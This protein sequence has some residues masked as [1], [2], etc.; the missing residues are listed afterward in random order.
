MET[1]G[2]FKPRSGLAQGLPLHLAGWHRACPYIRCWLLA[3]LLAMT[4]FA[5]AGTP[6]GRCGDREQIVMVNDTADIEDEQQQYEFNLLVFNYDGKDYRWTGDVMLT[7]DG[8]EVVNLSNICRNNNSRYIIGGS[9]EDQARAWTA[10]DGCVGVARG[11]ING[12]T[13]VT[14]GLYDPHYEKVND[15]DSRA[16]MVRVRVGIERKWYHHN[17]TMGIK[18]TWRTINGNEVS[19]HLK[20]TLYAANTGNIGWPTSNVTA[21]NF[22]RKGNHEMQFE[23]TFP[24][25]TITVGYTPVSW[26]SR[27]QLLREMPSTTKPYVD[28]TDRSAHWNSEDWAA[29]DGNMKKTFRVESNFDPVVIYPRLERYLASDYSYLD[30][31]FQPKYDRDYGVVVIGGYP[32][33]KNI[34]ATPNPWDK[35][36]SL[37]WGEEVPETVA[38]NVSDGK[39]YVYRKT[40]DGDITNLTSNGVAYNEK[41]FK[42]SRV[43]NMNVD[44]TYIVSYVPKSWQANKPVDEL[45]DTLANVKVEPLGNFVSMDSLQAVKGQAKIKVNWK[46]SQPIGISGNLTFKLYH[47][48]D[49]VADKNW[50][51]VADI[52]ANNTLG[53]NYSYTHDVSSFSVCA[54]HYYKVTITAMDKDYSAQTT[55]GKSVNVDGGIVVGTLNASKGMYSNVVKLRWD[56]IQIGDPITYNVYRRLL[57]SDSKFAP[58]GM[59]TDSKTSYTYEDYTVSP[60]DYY[61]YQVE[62]LSQC[63][64]T[65]GTKHVGREFD[66]ND[67]FCSTTGVVSGTINFGSG[68]AVKDVKVM[69]N[70][71]SDDA[72]N[73]RDQYHSASFNYV[74]GSNGASN[75]VVERSSLLVPLTDAQGK[76]MFTGKPWSIQMYVRVDELSSRGGYL[77]YAHNSLSVLATDAG[78]GYHLHI[79]WPNG[80]NTITNTELSKSLKYGRFYSVTYSYDGN[81]DFSLQVVDT[82]EGEDQLFNLKQTASYPSHWVHSGENETPLLFGD[83]YY[84]GKPTDASTTPSGEYSYGWRGYIDDIRVFSGRKLTDEEILKNYNHL[85]SGNEKNLAIYLPLDE[86]LPNQTTAYDMS[87]TGGVSNGHHAQFIGMAR[88]GNEVPDKDQLALFNYTDAQGN[89]TV[90]GV[91]I[92]GEGISYMVTPQLGVHEFSPAYATRFVSANSLIHSGVNFTDISSFPVSGRVLYKNTTIPVEGA[93]LT[94]DGLAASRNGKYVMTAADGT[95][96]IDVPI[97]EHFVGVEME[98]HV[99]ENDGRYPA[100]P[101]DEVTLYNFDRAVK[102]LTFYDVTTVIVA[103]RVAG[104]D[105]ENDKPLGLGD[106][107]ANIGQATVTLGITTD[108]HLNYVP[109]QEGTTVQYVAGK[110]TVKYESASDRVNSRAFV[111]VNAD[112]SHQNYITIKTD[113][114]TGEFTAKL[115]PLY[116]KVTGVT[117]DKYPTAQTMPAA[118]RD[119]VPI[120]VFNNLPFVDATNPHMEYTDTLHMP[121]STYITYVYNASAKIEYKAASILDVVENEDGTFG[122]DSVA[123]DTLDLKTGKTVSIKIPVRD[124]KDYVFDYPVY[125]QLCKYAYKLYGY[126]RYYNFDED[127]SHPKCYDVPLANCDVTIKNQYASTTSI[128]VKNDGE[129]DNDRLLEENNTFQLDSMGRATYNFMADLPNIAPPYTRHISIAYNNGKQNLTWTHPLSVYDDD[130]ED[131]VEVPF[132]AIVLGSLPT[133]N[134]FVT[135][136]PD[137]LLM[138]LRDP[139]GSNSSATYSKGTSFIHQRSVTTEPHAGLDV[140]TTFHLGLETNTGNGEGFY[141]IND[142][143]N[144]GDVT[145]GVQVSSSFSNTHQWVHQTFTTE[146]ISTSDDPDY[147]G[148]DGDLFIGV[149]KNLIFGAVHKLNIVE[150]A[151]EDPELEVVDALSIGEEFTT[152]FNY[153]QKYIKETLIPNLKKVRNS[154]LTKVS[155]K[156]ATPNT[157]DGFEPVYYTDLDEDDPKYG[158]S[159]SDISL[160]GVNATKFK[161]FN[162]TDASRVYDGPSYKAVFPKTNADGEEYMGQDDVAYY[163]TQISL[164]E[165]ELMKNEQTKVESASKGEAWLGEANVSFDAGATVTKTKEHAFD[166]FRTNLETEEINVII[167]EL[168]SHQWDGVGM[169]WKITETVGIS[170]TEEQS[171]GGGSSTSTSYTLSES[172]GDYLSVDVFKATDGFGPVFRTR[173]GATHCPYEDEVVTEYYSPGEIIMEKTMQV[174]IPEISCQTALITGIPAG[175]DAVFRVDL[176]NRSDKGRDG[177][178]NLYVDDKSNLNG[179]AVFM[180]GYNITNGRRI[181]LQAGE[182]L[183]KTFTLRQ[184]NPDVLTYD[185]IHIV[186]SSECQDDI[187]DTT[188]VSVEFVAA[189]SDIVL[190]ASTSVVNSET[191][192]PII[193]SMSG[194]N[195]NMT[196]LTGAL[197]QYKGANDANWTTLQEYVKNQSQ[198][199]NGKLLLE[200]LTGAQ[201]LDYSFDLASHQYTDQVYEFRALTVCSQNGDVVNGESDWVE[202]TRDITQPQ[203]LATP[204]PTSGVLGIG[205]DISILFNENIRSS[206]LKS[207]DNFFVRGAL[208]ESEVSH[209]VALSLTG[210]ET[211]KTDATINLSGKSFAANMWLNYSADGTLL[212]HGAKDNSFKVAIVDDGKLAVTV[213]K[214]THTSEQVLPKNKWIFLALSYDNS[215]TTPKVNASYAQDASTYNLMKNVE[216]PEYNG[217]GPVALGGSDLTAK[218]QEL[219]LWNNANSLDDALA[220]RYTTK[221]QYTNGLLG[222]WQFNEGHGSVAADRARQRSMT[223]P[224]AN[225]WF[226]D[227]PN[228]ALTLDGSSVAAFDISTINTLAS[229]DYLVEAWFRA[230]AEQAGTASVMSIGND[231][232]DLRLNTNGQLELSTVSGTDNT[233]NTALVSSADMRDG[234][235]HHVALN[236]LKSTNGNSTVYLDGKA[237]TQVR[238]SLMPA[239]QGDKLFL[240]GHRTTTA[241]TINYNQGLKGAIDEVRIWKGRRTADVIASTMYNRVE[242]NEPGL[243]AYFPLEQTTLDGN[244]QEVTAG[245]AGN[246]ATASTA[247]NPMTVWKDAD[248]MGAE[249]TPAYSNLSTPALTKVPQLENVMF[250]FVANERQITINMLEEPYKIEGCTIY[251]TA[252]DVKDLNGNTAPDITW[253]VYVQ[254]NRLKWAESE[255]SAVKYGNS[256]SNFSVGIENVSAMNENYEVTDLPLWLSVDK[257]SGNLPS[258]SSRTLNFTVDPSLAIGTYETTVFLKGTQ[259]ISA[260]LNITLTVEGD[261]PDWVANTYPGTMTVIGQLKINDEPSTDAKDMVAAFRGTE[262]VGVAQPKYYSRYDAYFVLLTIYGDK[263]NEALTYKAYDA[264]TGQIYASLEVTGVE[265]PYTFAADKSIGTFRSPAFFIPTNEIEQQIAVNT[266]GWKWFSLYA[267]PKV[268]E[269]GEVF[270]HAGKHVTNITG[271]SASAANSEDGW[272]PSAYAFDC[273]KM[274]KLKADSIVAESIIGPAADPD[275]TTITLAANGWSW[276]GYPVQASNSLMAAFGNLEPVDG[277]MVKSQTSFAMY[278][279][280]VWKGTL[281]GM[282]PGEGYMYLSNAGSAKTF[283]FTKPANAGNTNASRRADSESSVFSASSVSYKDNMTMIAVV[284]NGNEVVED[285]QVSVYDGTELCA[286]STEAVSDGL[287]FLTIGGTAGQ[288]DLLTFVISTEDGDYVVSTT[289]TFV[290][291]AHYGSLSQPFVLQL[292]N[293]TGIDLAHNGSSIKS[294]QLYDGSGRMLRSTECP[295]HIYT[296]NDLKSLPAGVYYQQ[297]TFTNGQTV[298]QKMMR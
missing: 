59:I 42:D 105:I 204:T 107:V 114:A 29:K 127:A 97:G 256:A 267:Q 280:T 47:S 124:K 7:L 153:T 250:N 125:E 271:F 266:P 242:D 57:G 26:Q 170:V 145:A 156:S 82:F 60:G 112:K 132:Q 251:L 1:N 286:L 163:N 253:S 288:A 99:F 232:L 181:F 79:G 245:Y 86:G 236:V 197:L 73:D 296:K 195:T 190:K 240:G 123:M 229:D 257:Q 96:E 282:T 148:A 98:G 206:A 244:N 246:R 203:L 248:G 290:A 175:G 183:T 13:A 161:G 77:V 293:A 8:V 273:S 294:I 289:E 277:D 16:I 166:K 120:P 66:T 283:T 33:A 208:N 188:S 221:S 109:E 218:V 231:K 196:S 243:V 119:S 184:T 117:L 210:N 27:V 160:W 199:G 222:Y 103:G 101:Y 14:V 137:Q 157:T 205:D 61:E 151:G 260:P 20:K 55:S 252:K 19:R 165:D 177:Y 87:K 255:V 81:K 269:V 68:T 106:G 80:S 279:G 297:V 56:A 259:G 15:Q 258:L 178:Y 133:G 70:R 22:T 129:V 186:L 274:Y 118:L 44:Y 28:V 78:D 295:E 21:G 150:K 219:V 291:N 247:V 249:L 12:L 52:T 171:E 139:P 122:A 202:V 285:A 138:V 152:N 58:I 69:L 284:M 200:P 54:P 94:V 215:G 49:T 32:K 292:A 135:K 276:I 268:N 141:V 238:S 34:N 239:L 142:I 223:L 270:K 17:Y 230:D 237:R 83:R 263:D 43:P 9:S 64:A 71:V 228:Y 182:T 102:N 189:C 11:S 84:Y 95:F 51:W 111:G 45:F 187:A 2:L 108:Y 147:D 116:Y 185:D 126:E 76:N 53:M 159:N 72:I 264:S 36:V 173:G 281:K 192:A 180:D 198:V 25:K 6:I 261:R 265:Y 168:F 67:G 179:A 191:T 233:A 201:T 48:T 89:Y 46:L 174:E 92:S 104:G 3:L 91:P 115:P 169:S 254:Q 287:H 85:L 65:N 31:T 130:E 227:G 154:L 278:S 275:N 241:N 298:V 235:W 5:M 234:Q 113:P 88:T 40:T 131:Y 23:V 262:C 176:R 207:L 100:D 224:S 211:V 39:W 37:T 24:S 143:E 74:S 35:S 272:T 212:Q 209:D 155:D 10:E 194:Y 167:G 220:S 18:G 164:W 4:Q 140:M 144:V 134:N 162:K 93:T 136:G 41:T 146:D 30:M 110:D 128:W 62:S 121:D 149:A 63:T 193:L 216:M 217:N 226:L 213:G 172:D 158:S 90:S 75:K 225:G 50:A 214:T 38:D